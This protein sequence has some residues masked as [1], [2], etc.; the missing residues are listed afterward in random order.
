MEAKAFYRIALFMWMLL[1][2]GHTEAANSPLHCSSPVLPGIPG[3]DGLPGRDGVPGLNGLPG[4]DGPVGPPGSCQEKD[5]EAQISD[6][7]R[8]LSDVIVKTVLVYLR[9]PLQGCTSKS[10]SQRLPLHGFS[11]QIHLLVHALDRE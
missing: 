8:L 10:L 9:L 1:L 4:R 2:I 3:R 6:R 7:L 11:N 5:V